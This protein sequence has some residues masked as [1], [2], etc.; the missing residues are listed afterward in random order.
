MKLGKEHALT[1]VHDRGLDCQGFIRNDCAFERL[2]PEFKPVVDATVLALVHQ[3]PEQLVG[4][5]LYGSVARGLAVV[6]R[7]DL[8]VSVVLNTPIGEEEREIFA[9][10]SG[11]IPQHYPEISKLDIDPGHIECIWEREQRYYWQFWL[12]HCCCCI[13]GED[14]ADG[15]S[16]HTPS[17]H[18][19]HALNGD[20]LTFTE[21]MRVPFSKMDDA[22]VVKVLGKKLIRAAYYFVAEQDNS[23][24]TD[25]A[26]CTE[27]AKRYYPEQRDD[28]QLAYECAIRA[29][30]CKASAFELYVRLSQAIM[31]AVENI[32][33]T[34]P[35]CE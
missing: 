25:L 28:L 23:W 9:Q 2:Q 21:Q 10:I 18:I 30:G 26:H 32:T 31:S 29:C 22:A 17:R 33:E 6:G 19:A 7:S 5:Y 1:A 14:L 15:L 35:R 12:K 3:F 16:P 13:W 11:Q 34:P 8:D 24:Y 20:L 4:I 27:V